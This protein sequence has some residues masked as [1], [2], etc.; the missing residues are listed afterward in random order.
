VNSTKLNIFTSAVVWVLLLLS[1]ILTASVL[2]PNISSTAIVSILVGGA[3]LG[4]FVGIV[5]VLLGHRSRA[6]VLTVP[7][8]WQDRRTWRMPALNRL[9]RPSLTLQRKIGLVAL[10]GYLLVA[11]ALVV[12]KVVE[13]A[14]R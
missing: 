6:G 10:R 9:A 12:V 4:L 14:L 8:A 13:V 1:V 7:V 5:M 11:F 2:F 3:V